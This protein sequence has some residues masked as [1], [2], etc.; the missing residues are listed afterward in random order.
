MKKIKLSLC[1]FSRLILL[2]NKI[3]CVTKTKRGDIIV[4]EPFSLHCLTSVFL[5]R[6]AVTHKC[7]VE[8]FKCAP[9]IFKYPR[10]YPKRVLIW[11]F[12]NI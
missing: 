11:L 2:V 4:F 7:A 8:F 3:A 5:N 1:L 10:K 9:Q 6:C 12:F